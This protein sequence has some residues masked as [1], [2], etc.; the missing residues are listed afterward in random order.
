MKK[1][2]LIIFLL[3]T[4]SGCGINK[5][6]T[7]NS[8]EKIQISQ[9]KNNEIKI[10]S[11]TYNNQEFGF[12][13][14]YPSNWPKINEGRQS[15]D[16]SDLVNDPAVQPNDEI[17]KNEDKIITDGYSIYFSDSY[18]NYR[19]CNEK[20]FPNSSCSISIR[21]IPISS[22][23][24]ISLNCY[25]GSCSMENLHEKIAQLKFNYKIDNLPA[26]LTDEHNFLNYYIRTVE[27]PR[28]NYL[29]Q[30]SL[31]LPVPDLEMYNTSSYNKT[32]NLDK[33]FSNLTNVDDKQFKDIYNVFKQFNDFVKT[34][35][36]H[37]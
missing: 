3:L 21:I 19:F 27:I 17:R 22:A 24:F 1:I 29:I 15:I 5:R 12:N 28:P 36:F 9:T 35:K 2:I 25:E 11:T 31:A 6:K 20:L 16:T 8:N 13:F 34:F 30:I 7:E 10:T 32:I 37:E 33:I 23:R 4:I 18:Q 26:S 14:S